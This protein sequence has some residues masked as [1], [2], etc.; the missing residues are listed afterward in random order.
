M[1]LLPHP[2]TEMMPLEKTKVVKSM[3]REITRRRMSLEQLQRGYASLPSEVRTNAQAESL[4]LATGVLRGFKDAD[5][6]DLHII[7]DN[8]KKGFLSINDSDPHRKEISFFR[9]MDLAEVIYNLQ[10]VP[11]FDECITRMP[12]CRSRCRA[13]WSRR[14]Q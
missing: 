3:P 4:A 13:G 7:S 2:T 14:P 10:P 6:V 11:G 8:R 5:W 12:P 1:R 9:V